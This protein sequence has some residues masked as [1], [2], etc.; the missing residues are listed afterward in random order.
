MTGVS[1]G[2]GMTVT[3]LVTSTLA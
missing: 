1:Q 3:V 2:D